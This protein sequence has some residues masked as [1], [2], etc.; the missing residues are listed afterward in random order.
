MVQFI[1]ME[2][3]YHTL[4]QPVIERARSTPQALTLV[5]MGEDGSEKLVTAAQFDQTSRQYAHALRKLGVAQDDLVVLVL[6]HSETLLYAFWGALYQGAMV[7]I[8]PFLTEKLDPQIYFERVKALVEHEQ[9][10]AVITFPEFYA[11]LRALLAE[12]GCLVLSTE[13]VNLEGHESFEQPD[14]QA[15]GGEKIAFLQHSSGTTGLQKGVALAHRAVLNQVR[16]CS[17][18]IDLCPEDV[19]VSW[20]PLY[21]DMGL[22]AGFVMPIV[23]GI[24]LVLMSPFQWVRDPKILLQAVTRWKATLCWLPNFAFNHL[25]RVV[26][27]RE[28][29]SFNLSSMRA[30]INCSEPVRHESHQLFLQKFGMCGFRPEAL[31]ACYGM[32]ENTFAVTQTVVGRMPDVDW[33]HTRQLQEQRRAVPALAEAEGATAMVSCGVPV[34]GTEVAVADEKGR[35]L[36]ERHVGELILRSD[37]MLSAYYR[38]PDVTAEAIRDGWY[39]TGDMGYMA[40]GQVFVSGRK[41]DL[42]IVGGKNIYPQDL[43]AIANLTPGLYPGRAVAFGMLDEELGSEAIVMVCELEEEQAAPE[44]LEAI[45]QDLRRRVVAQTEVALKDV[46]LVGRKWLIKTSSGKIARAANREKYLA[47]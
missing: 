45:E 29:E 4:V 13:Q 46:R 15:Q 5:Y 2:M 18:A 11:E 35:H 21:H 30:L 19:I 42:I 9:V 44:V 1:A 33:V 20:L 39:F 31:S 16:A 40:D 38:R 8:F 12:V 27:K 32:A 17:L 28:L 25:A 26:R 43:E 36:P 47:E 14:W 10:K 6:R 34:P 37:C 41:K 22:I 23:A 24:P 7:S 3:L